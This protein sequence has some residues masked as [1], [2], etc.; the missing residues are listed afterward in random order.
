MAERLHEVKLQDGTL[1]RHKVAGYQGRIDG[2]TAIKEC[3]TAGGELLGK[4]SPRHAFQYRV[5]VL[6]EYLRRIAP[7][8]DLEVLEGVTTVVCP[9]CK[10]SF[11]SEPGAEGKVRG[12]C[13]CGEWICPA[14]LSC[15]GPV[16]DSKKAADSG[17]L[18]QRKRLL[19]KAAREKKRKRVDMGG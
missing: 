2:T 16:G 3:F 19:S 9:S 6:G 11:Q 7:A 13:D 8:E 5:A 18:K 4:V 14:C 12:R 1:I 10:T 17:C 15:Q